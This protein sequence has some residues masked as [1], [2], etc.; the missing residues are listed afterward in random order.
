[1]SSRS[2]TFILKNVSNTYLCFCFQI[3]TGA[4]LV[5]NSFIAAF[6][7]YLLVEGP[8]TSV[9]RE[10]YSKAEPI[11]GRKDKDTKEKEDTEINESPK[12]NGIVRKRV[13]NNLVDSSLIYQS[14]EK[15]R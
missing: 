4:T 13:L 3:T 8:F 12:T 10:F 2:P 5:V 11:E 15:H 7:F 9:I 14:L 1:M 6:F